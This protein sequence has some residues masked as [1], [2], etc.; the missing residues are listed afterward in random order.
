MDVANES[1][2]AVSFHYS[3]QPVTLM[4]RNFSNDSLITV[5]NDSFCRHL[6]YMT[7]PS[8]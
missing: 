7:I 2:T 4:P 3:S 8:S 5:A 1:S 6:L